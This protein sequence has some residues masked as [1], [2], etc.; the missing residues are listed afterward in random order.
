MFDIEERTK[1]QDGKIIL[2]RLK[3]DKV[4]SV[5]E[6]R[7]PITWEGFINGEAVTIKQEDRSAS[8]VFNYVF[9]RLP[10]KVMD[11][12][13]DIVKVIDTFLKRRLN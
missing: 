11:Y 3:A 10:E 2:V 1:A 4:I 12:K 6:I 7:Y 8:S 13:E 9:D 5:F